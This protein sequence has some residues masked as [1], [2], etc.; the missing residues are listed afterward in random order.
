MQKGGIV[1]KAEIRE[2]KIDR[3]VELRIKDFKRSLQQNLP[4][5]WEWIGG[6]LRDG[7][8]GLNQMT[9]TDIQEILDEWWIE[10][11]LYQETED[12]DDSQV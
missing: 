12:P 10:E 8:T 7:H 9:C 2:K 6:I 4:Y 3:V 5:L 1:T 11:K